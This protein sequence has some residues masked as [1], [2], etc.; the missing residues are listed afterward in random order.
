VRPLPNDPT[1]H[2]VAGG[3]AGP[4]GLGFR[5]PAL[6]ISPFSRGGLVYSGVLD[7]TSMLRFVETRFGARVPNLSAWRRRTTGDMTGAF[8]FAAR[9]VLTAPRLPNVSGIETACAAP[10]N[11]T[12]V[13]YVDQPFPRQE[14][15]RRGRPS[16]PVTPT[17]A[18]RPRPSPPAFTG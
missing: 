16:G 14:P 4:I 13:Q 7:H 12:P 8:N 6:V 3:F 11:R 9:P 17:S 10:E 2:G 18:V 5:V 1:F 15:G